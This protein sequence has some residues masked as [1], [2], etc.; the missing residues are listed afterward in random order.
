MY[1]KNE[2]YLD[3]AMHYFYKFLDDG[4]YPPYIFK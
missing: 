3:D 1:N 2:I 4:D